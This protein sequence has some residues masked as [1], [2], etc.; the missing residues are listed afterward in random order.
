MKHSASLLAILLI[1]GFVSAPAYADL[2]NLDIGG[3]IKIEGVYVTNARD[4]NDDGAERRANGRPSAPQ[5]RDPADDEDAFVRTEGHLWFQAELAENVSGRISIEFDRAWSNDDATLDE[6]YDEGES[7]FGRPEDDDLDLFL[8]EAYIKIAD[9]Y[10]MP[11]TITIGRQFVEVGDGFVL[12]DSLPGSPSS[13]EA[14]GEHEQDPFDAIRIDYELAEDWLLTAIWSK[15]VETRDYQEDT[16]VYMLNLGFYGLEGHVIEAYLFSAR[17]DEDPQV[18]LYQFGVRAE[19]DIGGG[20]GYHGEA[21]WQLADEIEFAADDK[22]IGGWAGEIGLK[23]APPAMEANEVAFG[24]SLAFLSGD[25]DQADS[26]YEAYIQVAEN[27]TY[28]EIADFFTG[29]VNS[30]EI[31]ED[32]AGV[33]IFNLDAQAALSDRLKA[34]IE[35]YYFISDEDVE[36][37]G[38]EDDSIGWEID[39]FLTYDITEDL[40]A[41]LAAGF[42]DPDDAAEIWLAREEQIVGDDLAWFIRGGVTLTF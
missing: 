16:D 12:G 39:G 10:G 2:D 36:F 32:F 27:R 42:F 9:L 40:S 24:L 38:E 4:F 6:A 11:A 14:L 26:D 18:S 30:N 7:N 33:F 13:I 17:V 15:A 41:Q 25:D 29:L 1:A 34:A 8:E 37:A 19:G 28:G 20:L 35:A 22:D 31:D 3:K 21:T 23:L 5:Q